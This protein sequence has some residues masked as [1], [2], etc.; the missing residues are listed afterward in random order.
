MPVFVWEA[1]G[2][3]ERDVVTAA[4]KVAVLELVGVADRV[5]VGVTDG[6]RESVDSA[7]DDRVGARVAVMVAV[8]DDVGVPMAA[9]GDIVAWVTAAHKLS[10]AKAHKRRILA[11]QHYY[12]CSVNPA[13]SKWE[14]PRCEAVGSPRLNR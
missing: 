14:P 13:A 8:R 5:E 10:A 6:D 3:P 1:A 12:L 9:E 11:R 2:E 7:V 4:G